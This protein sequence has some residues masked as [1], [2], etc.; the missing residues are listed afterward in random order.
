MQYL[1][2]LVA[3]STNLKRRL[4]AKSVDYPKLTSLVS[5][6]NIALYV[7]PL[8]KGDEK[9]MVL[10]FQ[11]ATFLKGLCR[12]ISQQ[13]KEKAS[14]CRHVWVSLTFLKTSYWMHALSGKLTLFNAIREGDPSCI[15]EKKFKLGSDVDMEDLDNSF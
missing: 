12:H 9:H 13:S 7:P 11:L 8:Q 1:E 5:L 10:S 15:T 14:V 3:T 6:L 4:E 2:T